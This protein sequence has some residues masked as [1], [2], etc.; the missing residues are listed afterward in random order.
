MRSLFNNVIPGLIRQVEPFPAEGL[1]GLVYREREELLAYVELKY[2]L[3]GIWVQPF[4]HPDA[5]EVAGWL[6]DLL[7]LPHRFSRPVYLCIRS[8]QSWL[9]P[10]LEE[11]GAE[12]GP[13][14]AV[15]VK[16]LAIPQKVAQTFALP[17]LEGRHP[18]V[19]TP[20]AQSEIAQRKSN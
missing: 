11:L 12:A 6:I 20:F 3:R 2:G 9:E 17:A 5:E 1:R 10:A 14:Q 4:V 19:T 16:H 8:Y 7:Q 18:E 13:R 15:M